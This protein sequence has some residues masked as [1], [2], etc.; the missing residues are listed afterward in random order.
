M[1]LSLMCEISLSS[2]KGRIHPRTPIGNGLNT[3]P[4]N[5]NL[6]Q[7]A[8]NPQCSVRK[9]ILLFWLCFSCAT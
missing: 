9:N 2:H 1:E 3:Y 6:K 4:V 7:C 8:N 5:N